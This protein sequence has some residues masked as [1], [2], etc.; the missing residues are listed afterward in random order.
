MI[1]KTPDFQH[2]WRFDLYQVDQVIDVD[3]LFQRFKTLKR[4]QPDLDLQ[5]M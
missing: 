4:V 3:V 2:D 1:Y 5:V